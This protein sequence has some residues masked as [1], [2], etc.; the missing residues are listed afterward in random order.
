MTYKPEGSET[1][2]LRPKTALIVDDEAIFRN[3]HAT[4]L[5]KLGFACETAETANSAMKMMLRKD[6][7]VVLM[8]IRLD[9]INEDKKDGLE[10]IRSIRKSKPDTVIIGVSAYYSAKDQLEVLKAGASGFVCKSGLPELIQETVLN[11]LH[12]AGLGAEGKVYKY[13]DIHFDRT[14]KT[15]R[16]GEREFRIPET[17]ANI[18]AYFMKHPCELVKNT[19]L[20]AAAWPYPSLATRENRVYDEVSKLRKRLCEGGLNDPIYR[21]HGV[22]YVFS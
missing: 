11:T 3:E 12:L 19:E 5:E 15:V 17:Q 6:Y 21:K 2:K 14:T 9:G 13:G 8:D 1:P 7:D 18:L 16:R 10:V 22:G 4:A 20:Y